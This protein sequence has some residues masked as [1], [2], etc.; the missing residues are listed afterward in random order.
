M[1]KVGMEPIRKAQLI[2]ATL[3]SIEENGLQGTTIAKICKISGLAQGIVSHYFG[4]KQQLIEATV[5]YLI[6]SLQVELVK[7]LVSIDPDDHVARLY[8]I[9]DSNFSHIQTSKPSSV[10]WISFWAQSAHDPSLA[11]LQN[12]NE[13]R[14]LSNIKYS[15]KRLVS[16]EEYVA[17]SQTLAALIDG[18]WLRSALS[19]GAVTMEQSVELCKKYIDD[20]AGVTH[21]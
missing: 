10:T 20:V 12:I 3:K 7:K 18:L 8:A 14:L 6:S 19:Q 2:D 11:R 15:M 17:V 5:W 9:I 13:R 1:P 4:G 16:E 21:E